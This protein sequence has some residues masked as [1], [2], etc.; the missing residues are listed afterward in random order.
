M[1]IPENCPECGGEIYTFTLNGQDGFE[2]KVC[3]FM[4]VEEFEVFSSP[5]MEVELTKALEKE[6]GIKGWHKR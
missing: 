4:D 2:C 6:T 3:E 5:E 1:R